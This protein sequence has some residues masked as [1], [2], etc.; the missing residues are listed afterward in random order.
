[1]AKA[2]VGTID[3]P[4]LIPDAQ[5]LLRRLWAVAKIEEQ[6]IAF[7]PLHVAWLTPKNISNCLNLLV[8]L[9]GKSKY[10]VF[11]EKLTNEKLEE[12]GT[13][14]KEYKDVIREDPIDF[15]TIEEK[16]RQLESRKCKAK[17]DPKSQREQQ[18]LEALLVDE[19][20]GWSVRRFISDLVLVIRNALLFNPNNH[21]IHKSAMSA[22]NDL[23]EY[24]VDLR[25]KV[26]T[27]VCLLYCALC[28]KRLENS[29]RGAY[30]NCTSCYL[31]IHTK[32]DEG[33][34]G[35]PYRCIKCKPSGRSRKRKM[36]DEN[37]QTVQSYKKTILGER[38]TS[39]LERSENIFKKLN[40]LIKTAKRSEN[41]KIS[42]DRRIELLRAQMSAARDKAAKNKRALEEKIR[43]LKKRLKTSSQPQLHPYPHTGP[44]EPH[45]QLQV[46]PQCLSLSHE[47]TVMP[48]TQSDA[49]RKN[50]IVGN[51]SAGPQ[52]S[53]ST[54]GYYMYQP[55][56][57]RPTETTRYGTHLN[58]FPSRLSPRSLYPPYPTPEG[59]S[60][61]V[62]VLPPYSPLHLTPVASYGLRSYPI[63]NSKL[64]SNSQS[65]MPMLANSREGQVD[66]GLKSNYSAQTTGSSLTHG[67]FGRNPG[68][69][70]SGY[71]RGNSAHAGLNSIP[72]GT[73][74]IRNLNEVVAKD[75]SSIY[76]NGKGMIVKKSTRGIPISDT[77][78][79]SR[80]G[81][82]RDSIQVATPI[83]GG[84]S[85]NIMAG[86]AT[87]I[88][89]RPLLSAHGNRVHPNIGGR[90]SSGSAQPDYSVQFTPP[91]LMGTSR[92]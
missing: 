43:F 15:S 6:H 3:R 92:S 19:P 22:G 78:S 75:Q 58:V 55:S 13:D 31:F 11:F 16:L 89:A 39:L 12:Y 85:T 54:M 74:N 90:D 26:E 7:D 21:S 30:R 50:S 53:D 76:P 57:H 40:A 46:P 77:K 80:R 82:T 27:P 65:H 24:L 51:N 64:S 9:G 32:C 44:S 83:V 48:K 2:T 1:M 14:I 87:P 23:M 84:H 36:E 59:H 70:R 49:Q 10:K 73:L 34:E 68:S 18:N 5:R 52:T 28:E 56:P 60:T 63:A 4:R 69:G 42:S 41:A 86:P 38:D 71:F 37:N 66:L 8:K 47:E 45:L 67:F 88:A 20:Y 62:P 91:G 61:P 25:S 33:D 29:S 81:L 79:I 35:E 72:S 17:L